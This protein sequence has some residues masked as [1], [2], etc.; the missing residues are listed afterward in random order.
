MMIFKFFK[1]VFTASE[2]F[3]LNG[4]VMFTMLDGSTEVDEDVYDCIPDHG[5]DNPYIMHKQ[6][7]SSA[8]TNVSL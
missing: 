2:K 6:K 1:P 7:F 5:P 8:L 4:P 3:G